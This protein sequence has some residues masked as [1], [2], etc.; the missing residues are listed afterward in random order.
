[1]LTAVSC[2]IAL[3]FVV[4]CSGSSGQ[5][6]SDAG[7]SSGGAA[8]S[9]AGGVGATATGGSSGSESGGTA[10]AATGGAAAGGGS[11]VDSCSSCTGVGKLCVEFISQGGRQVYATGGVC[12]SG[13]SLSPARPAVCVAQ[14]GAQMDARDG[15]CPAGSQLEPAFPATCYSPPSY[16]CETLPPECSTAP[17]ST[18]VA[19][20]TCAGSLCSAP[21]QCSDPSPTTMVCALFAP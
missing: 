21:Y 9:S 4:A 15:G 12:P 5:R 18:A 14:G 10:G 11:A 7:A 8:G 19:H 6:A 20:C 1:M 2:L 3:P 13:L 16:S 17:G